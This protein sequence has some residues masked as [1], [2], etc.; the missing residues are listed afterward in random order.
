MPGVTARCLKHAGGLRAALEGILL[1]IRDAMVLSGDSVDG[2]VLLGV[3]LRE[4]VGAVFAGLSHGAL[5]GAAESVAR[6]LDLTRH[7]YIPSEA[8]VLENV[9]A[10]VGM[11]LRRSG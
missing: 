2:E 4:R 7:L 3:D 10:D 5:L 11:S 8:L 9:L 1:L 6:G